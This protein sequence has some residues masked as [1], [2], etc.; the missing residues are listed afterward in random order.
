MAAKLKTAVLG[1]TGYSGLEL[2][3]ILLRHP[4]LAKPALLKR[5]GENGST[6]L[7]DIFPVLSGNG[8]YPLHSLSWPS[9]KQQGVDLLF[10]ATPHE[11]SRALVPEAISHGLRV[12]DLSGAWRLKKEQHRGIYGFTD[13]DSVSATQLTEQAVYGL[14]EL[15]ADKIAKADLVANPGCYATSVILALAPLL[16]ADVVDR[17]RVL[18]ELLFRKALGANFSD[19]Q[20]AA[21]AV[22]AAHELLRPGILP[23]GRPAAAGADFVYRQLTE[24]C[25]R[26]GGAEYESDVRVERGRRTAVTIVIKVGG[27]A[28]ED[29]ATLRKCARAIAE[30]AQDGHRV[31][32]VHGGGGAL[33]RVLKQLGKQ[34]EFVGGLRITDA[35]TRDVALMVLGGMVNKKMVAAIQA[36][37]MPAVGFCG[38]DG[39]T[40]RARRKHMNGNDLGFVGEICFAEPCWIEALWQQGGIPVLASL[41]LGADGEYYNVNAD[42][43]AAACEAACH[44]NALIFLTDVPGVKDA[45]GTVIPWLSTR[46]AQDLADGSVISGGMLPKL[47]AC[48]QALKQGVGRVRI[49]PAAEAEALPQ[50]YLT[51]LNCG[52]EVTCA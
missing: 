21:G 18:S 37:G 6:D 13:A 28:L 19:A 34:S 39:M 41:A 49:L 29:I 43:M 38:G 32:V 26:T 51:K 4:R 45:E 9:M 11:V 17:S 7:A 30:L 16:K 10:L 36:A 15:N 1:A 12:I 27:A 50:F 35:E 14:P 31:V 40:F 2:T 8:G 24:G 22:F 44:A 3:R 23:G 42:E 20:A 5:A 46:Q 47:A 33:T 25:G 48:T 52:T